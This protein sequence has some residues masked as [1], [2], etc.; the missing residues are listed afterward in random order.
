MADSKSDLEDID[1][2][3]KDVLMEVIEDLLGTPNFHVGLQPGS[4]KGENFVGVVYRIVFSRKD[5]DGMRKPNGQQHK[6]QDS[7][8]FLKISPTNEHHR[9]QMS[10][11]ACF[12]CEIYVYNEVSMRLF[13]CLW[14]NQR[15]FF[16][17]PKIFPCFREFQKSKGILIDEDGF[18]EYPTC[19]RTIDTELIESVFL[20]DLGEQM[21]RMVN[22]HAEDVTV[23][24]IK[25]VMQVL[26]KFHATSLALKDQQPEKFQS[27]I[28]NLDEIFFQRQKADFALYINC[29][30]RTLFDAITDD[31]DAPLLLYLV[32]LFE[33]DQLEMCLECID[34]IQAEPY[35]VINHGTVS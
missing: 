16:L 28:S 7:N 2:N 3:I 18:H 17:S 13:K 35:A 6:K 21:F 15:F 20:E 31:K 29:L 22:F 1:S 10:A 14:F 32:R 4:K 27:L 33:R 12:L 26:G 23:P 24:H 8:L 5:A 30:P 19:Y 34:P 9:K 25:L 11:R